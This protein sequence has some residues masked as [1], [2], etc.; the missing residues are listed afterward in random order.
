MEHAP[1]IG[2]SRH[3]INLDGKGVTTLA[4]F[5]GCPLR[6]RYC[7]N[8]QCFEAEKQMW[9]STQEVYDLVRRDQL[10]FLATGGGVT[11]GGGEPLLRSRFIR[12][13]RAL[14]GSYWNLSVETSL[15]VE[16]ERVE[17]LSPIVNHWIVDIK[18]VDS[19]V[20]RAYTGKDNERVISN[21]RLL[22]AQRKAAH[23]T[24]R[25]PLIAGYND[26]YHR[27]KS[28]ARLQDMGYT[29]FDLF[30]YRTETKPARV[31]NKNENKPT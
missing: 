23:V 19:M 29:D 22:A 30:T 6:C 17:M 12:E 3:R 18:D 20:Y 31:I 28:I 11:F 21:L 16:A 26:E 5:G 24:L 27:Q 25:I 15:N 9:R 7:L 13:F 10:Y 2:I 14:C 1:F 4:C 8:P